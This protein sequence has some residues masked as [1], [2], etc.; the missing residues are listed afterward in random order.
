MGNY[1]AKGIAS[2]LPATSVVGVSRRGGMRDP[3]GAYPENL[4]FAKGNCLEPESMENE[5]S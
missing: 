3:K 2:A 4:A 5:L 1:L